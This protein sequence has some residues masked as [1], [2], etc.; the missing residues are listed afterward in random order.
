ML[1]QSFR[2]THQRVAVLIDDLRRAFVLISHNLANFGVDTNRRFFRE[3]AVKM[4]K[5]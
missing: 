1:Q 4:L 3:V 5:K 2:Q